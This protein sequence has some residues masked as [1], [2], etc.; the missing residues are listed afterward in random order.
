LESGVVFYRTLGG[1]SGSSDVRE[2]ARWVKPEFC[3]FMPVCL[4][5]TAKRYKKTE[6]NDHTARDLT[7]IH[8]K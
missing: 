1:N 8:G 7:N 4:Q 2:N 3:C 6:K 5:N